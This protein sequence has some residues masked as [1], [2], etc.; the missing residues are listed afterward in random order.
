[1][2]EDDKRPYEV[3]RP[4]AE[5]IVEGLRPYCDRIE[6]AGSLR[7]HRPTIGD[8]EVV[9]I[10]I[11]T[12]FTDL[13]GDILQEIN[14]LHLHLDYLLEKQKI[15]KARS[16]KGRTLWGKKLRRF[17]I[18]TKQ[19]QT[20]H[21]DLFMCD[22]NNWGNTYL[23]RTGSKDFSRWMVTRENTLYRPGIFG[24]LPLTMKHDLGRL[25]QQNEEDKSQWD[26]VPFTEESDWFNLVQLPFIPP[27][28]REDDKW[29][30]WMEELH[31]F[32]KAEGGQ[33]WWEE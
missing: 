23:I 29:F 20:Y 16:D 2:S 32:V 13:F 25:W 5:K 21:I 6:I 1:M 4:I 11:M 14:Q 19:G 3:V 7:R 10:P 26:A 31:Q 24:P 12:D 28:F 22:P 15:A 27:Q 30:D 8:I 33:M 18:T 17:G 9:A